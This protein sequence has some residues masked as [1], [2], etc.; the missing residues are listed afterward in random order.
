MIVFLS[1]F[2]YLF[3]GEAPTGMF[4]AFVAATLLIALIPGAVASIRLASAI[5]SSD[6]TAQHTLTTGNV[7]T[8]AIWSGII[9]NAAFAIL[10]I[11][12]SMG[13]LVG[14][15]LPYLLAGSALVAITAALLGLAATRIV[16]RK[17]GE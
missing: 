5:K 8:R 9:V 11:I 7:V 14:F 16:S 13:M 15:L 6:N 12:A 1:S 10:G 4:P 2:F 3:G 17:F